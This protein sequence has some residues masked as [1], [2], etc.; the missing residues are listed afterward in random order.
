MNPAVNGATAGFELRWV[1]S[2]NETNLPAD[3]MADPNDGS[4]QRKLRVMKQ[5]FLTEQ[6]VDSAGFTKY[7]SDQKELSVFL[8]P[9]GG[10]QFAAVT[11]KN[12]GRRLAIVWHGR[13]IAAPVVQS[14]ITGRRVSISGNF[15]DAEAQQLLDLLNH[16]GQAST[17]TA[18]PNSAAALDLSFGPVIERVITAVGDNLKGSEPD[19][20]SGQLLNMP[21]G[22]E[23]WPTQPGEQ[24]MYDHHAELF[25]ASLGNRWRLVGKDVAVKVV[26]EAQ[27]ATISVG[28]L[29]YA[30]VSDREETR[31]GIE[32]SPAYGFSL[33]EL[34]EP[35]NL[36]RTFAFQTSAG[37]LGLLQVVSLIENPPG[38]KLRYKLVRSAATA[39]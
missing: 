1:A 32:T 24:W 9:R 16:R 19:L 5:V 21:P 37:S 27:W 8:S 22:A 38:V 4:G 34:A 33:I 39:E 15:S 14:A 36:S 6:D 28:E 20:D 3:E 13:V 25:A 11:A 17:S 2:D 10:E 26:S 18:N 12:I 35:A 30:L 31:S 29:R 7:Q 23:Q